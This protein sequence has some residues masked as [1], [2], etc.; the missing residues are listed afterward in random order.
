METVCE[1]GCECD[2]PA[3]PVIRELDAQDRE[4]WLADKIQRMQEQ[5]E[6]LRT[7]GG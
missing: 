2:A 3:Q 4:Q 1:F 5:Q 6:L 7:V